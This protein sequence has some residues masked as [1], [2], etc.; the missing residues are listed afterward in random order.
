MKVL[1]PLFIHSLVYSF[2][3]EIEAKQLIRKGPATIHVTGDYVCITTN[4]I[5]SSFKVLYI[6]KNIRNSVNCSSVGACQTLDIHCC[7]GHTETIDFQSKHF[8][9]IKTT[10]DF[11]KCEATMKKREKENCDKKEDCSSNTFEDHLKNVHAKPLD[12]SVQS[13]NLR[14]TNG[15]PFGKKASKDDESVLENQVNSAPCMYSYNSLDSAKEF[16]NIDALKR[17]IKSEDLYIRSKDLISLS[18]SANGNFFASEEKE[19]PAPE[20]FSGLQIHSPCVPK[21]ESFQEQDIFMGFNGGPKL[22]WF[23]NASSLI[24]SN[25]RTVHSKDLHSDISDFVPKG[26]SLV[27]QQSSREH[28]GSQQHNNATDFAHCPSPV[29]LEDSYPSLENLPKDNNPQTVSPLL[30]PPVSYTIP[31]RT[32][33]CI[34]SKDKCLNNL[35]SVGESHKSSNDTLG[36]SPC[37]DKTSLLNVSES[38]PIQESADDIQEDSFKMMEYNQPKKS[39]KLRQSVEEWIPKNL[40][41]VASHQNLDDTSGCQEAPIIPMK[42]SVSLQPQNHIY[43]NVAKM[44]VVK[45][46]QD[47]PPARVR[48]PS[49]SFLSS[50]FICSP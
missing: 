41:Q 29:F 15:G 39:P 23:G 20:T 12:V 40:H 2:P 31:Q 48:L 3:I 34:T 45:D 32:P 36:Y 28:G 4:G 7:D 42:R 18:R 22:L 25:V 44:K 33:V 8:S 1:I 35:D 30:L 37:S 16:V 38:Q 21:T 9:K 47:I 11:F 6:K 46:R 5:D 17:E 50:F 43:E 27:Q 24:D 26:A 10:I 14:Y 49:L 19:D 13:T